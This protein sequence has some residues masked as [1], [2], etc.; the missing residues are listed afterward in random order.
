MRKILSA[1][2]LVLAGLAGTA[3]TPADGDEG[4]SVFLVYSA[5]ERSEL[6]PCG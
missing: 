6:V 2:L 3:G 5:D 1:L 4:R